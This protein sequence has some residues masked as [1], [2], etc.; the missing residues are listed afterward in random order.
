VP[1]DLGWGVFWWY[2]E[3]RPVSGLGVWE[4]GRYGLFDQNGNLLPAASVFEEFIDPALPGD[5]NGDGTVDAAD[6]VVWRKNGGTP[7]EYATWRANFGQTAGGGADVEPGA[8]AG[9]PEPATLLLV[10]SNTLAVFR[11]RF[12]R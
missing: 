5:F 6:Y 3:A 1:N 12:S 8:N 7:E 9:V 11:L 10:L 2:P 4:G